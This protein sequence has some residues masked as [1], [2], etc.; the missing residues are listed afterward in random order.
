MAFPQ[1]PLGT[2]VRMQI[3]G[4]WT[5]VTEHAQ[6]KDLITHQRGRTSEGQAVD[7]ASCTLTLKSPGGLYAYRN[8]RSPYYGKLGKNTPMQV[9]VQAGD[10]YLDLPGTAGAASTPDTAALDITGDLD[11]RWEGEADWYAA[12]AQML[13]AKWG[14]AGQRSY[15][16]RLQA[17]GLYIHTTQDGTVGRQH[18]VAL[19][20]GLPRRAA[21]RAVM[22][23]D[24]GSGG[25][26][27]RHYWAESLD[28][29]WTQFGGDL[30]S[31]GTVAIFSGSSPLTIAPEQLDATPPRQAVTGRCF[32]AEVR[33]GVGGTIVAAP[34]FRG[35]AIGATSFVDAA[36]R[37]WTMSGSQA[38]TSEQTR[39]FGEYSDWPTRSSRGGHLVTVEG[40]GAGLLRRL[41]QGTKEL[42]ST[43]RRRVPSY[44]P[45]AYWPMEE[46]TDATSVYSPVPGVKPFTPKNLDFAADDT[47][48]GSAPLPVVQV[49]ASFVAQVPPVPAGTWQVE[50]VYNLDT[51]PA[52]STT[53]FEVRTTGTARRVR[54]RVMTGQV[55][56]EGLGPDDETVFTT[57]SLPLRFT[58]AWARLQIR[59]VQ[60]GTN[61]TYTFRWIIIG[62]TGFSISST[63][64]ASPGYVVDVRSEFGAGLDGLR[65]GHLAVFN[66]M[67]DVPFNSA[68]MAFNGETAGARMRR[69][70]EEEGVA[71]R[72]IGQ[73][74]ETALMGP[75]RP[76]TLLALL[77]ECA[78]ADGGLLLE[79]RDAL[80][81]IYRCRT[82]LYNQTP[83]LTL[84]YRQK[85]L[86]EL[87]PVDDDAELRNDWTVTRTGGSSGR[88]EVTSGPLSVADPPVGVG[89][90]DDSATLNL[91]SDDQTEPMAWWLVHLGTV[92]EARYPAVTILLHRAPEL[93]PTIL[94][95]TEGDLIRITDLPDWL[96]PGPV[97]LIVQGLR[98]EIGVRTWTVTLV[99][100]PGSPWRVGVVED[101][102]LGR[103]DTDGSQLA[104][105]AAA[106]DTTMSIAVTAGP[107]WTSS[108]GEM[109]F[110]LRVGGEVVTVTAPG[111]LP[112]GNAFFD[113]DTTGWSAESA[114][115]SRS[116]AV[117][118]PDPHARGSLLITPTGGGASFAGAVGT[119]TDP[120]SITPGTSYVMSA[121][122]YSPGGWSDVRPTTYWY[123]AAGTFL[124]TG[125]GSAAAV[126]AGQWTFLTGTFAAPASA[127][128]A[129]ARIRHGATP[130]ATDLLYVWAARIT[131]TT[132]GNGPQTFTVVRAV[133][134]VVKGHAVGTDVRLA[135]PTIVAL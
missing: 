129:R 89:R 78:D 133:N 69:L 43:L 103:V 98:E 119:L 92:D 56:L 91:N 32:R 95:L 122:V 94:D 62:D 47:L 55:L 26:T 51:L 22:D 31:A 121:W 90:Y 99:C 105:A 4:V 127:S 58:G 123:D 108:P 117:V 77:Q 81:L 84:S 40:E 59:A 14:A 107:L 27:T 111:V 10:R 19:P 63:V 50:L 49:G 70:C 135:T 112:T 30:V 60:S 24:N 33:S 61:V 6:L 8:P 66:R 65:F 120:G 87:E 104:A 82:S 131:P 85:G 57:S 39:F 35:Q 37:T 5:D 21:V 38:V 72:L 12:G 23:V 9:S 116:T 52:A 124:S 34:D 75:Q 80:G 3:G 28:G 86:A 36:G 101:A 132:A 100:A 20:P 73:E 13:I 79:E 110:D 118:H 106:G 7:P 16:L 93:I 125:S 48:P 74:A 17:G 115:L 18:F 88:A 2:R 71:F 64:T 54:G 130:T 44:T 83:S 96:P 42:Q 68:D 29:P 126:P 45:V 97:D 67:T 15:N 76:A 109:P 1:D 41:N 128:R 53:L 134:G 25:V 102:V 46:G 114:T 113:T 11:L